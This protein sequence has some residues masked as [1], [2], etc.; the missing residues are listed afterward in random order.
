LKSGLWVRQM[1]TYHKP[2]ICKMLK[3]FP[4]SG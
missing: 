3:G 1:C 4:K 2:Y